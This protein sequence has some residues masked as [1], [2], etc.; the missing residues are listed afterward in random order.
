MLSTARRPSTTHRSGNSWRLIRPPSMAAFEGE[1]PWWSDVGA[2]QSEPRFSGWWVFN[3]LPERS[4]DDSNEYGGH[5]RLRDGEPP[6]RGEGDRGR[7]P[8]VRGDLG[9]GRR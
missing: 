5:H 8:P 3:T 6:E 1:F 2:T 9:P 4:L 7:R